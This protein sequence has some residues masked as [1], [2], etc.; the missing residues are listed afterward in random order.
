[1]SFIAGGNSGPQSPN[2]QVLLCFDSREGRLT[3]CGIASGAKVAARSNFQHNR[4]LDPSRP[5]RS[6]LQTRVRKT[7]SFRNQPRPTSADGSRASL[8]LPRGYPSCQVAGIKSRF[9]GHCMG[10]DIIIFPPTGSFAVNPFY[11]MLY[12]PLIT[13][14]PRGFVAG[15]NRKCD[16]TRPGT[17][18]AAFESATPEGAFAPQRQAFHDNVFMRTHLVRAF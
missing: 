9:P 1:M 4:V 2:R 17:L 16:I 5:R 12:N 7:M 13:R 8:S 15:G 3:T 18:P 14:P 10:C 11:K 6:R